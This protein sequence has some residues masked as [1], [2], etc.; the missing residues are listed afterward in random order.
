MGA[1]AAANGGQGA[2]WD[3]VAACESGGR[4]HADTGNGYFGGLQFDRATWRAN[5]GTA[6]AARPDLASREQ[7]IAVADHLAARRGLAPWPVCGVRAGRTGP[8]HHT[9]PSPR[10]EQ[11]QPAARQSVA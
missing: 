6:Y 3:K 11:Q 5:G 7:Q 1:A 4:W 8:H 2:D 9:V 10:Q